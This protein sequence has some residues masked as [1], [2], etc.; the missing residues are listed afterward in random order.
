[1]VWISD[2]LLSS[3]NWFGVLSDA[4][5]KSERAALDDVSEFGHQPQYR[6]LERI[7]RFAILRLTHIHTYAELPAPSFELFDLEVFNS[8]R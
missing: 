2:P 8:S 6:C 5:L 4:E 3:G 7:V 1:M